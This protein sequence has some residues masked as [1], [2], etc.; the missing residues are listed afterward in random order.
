VAASGKNLA[1]TPAATSSF[2]NVPIRIRTTIA[3]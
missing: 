3:R 2:L 1:R